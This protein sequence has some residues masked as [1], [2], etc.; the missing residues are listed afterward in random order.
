METIDRRRA[1]GLVAGA[2]AFALGARAAA[3]KA[4]A[5]ATMWRDPGCDCCVGWARRIEAALGVKLM[6]V[7]SPDMAAVKRARGVPAPLRSCHTALIGGFAI[8]GHVPPEDIKRLIA[9]RPRGVAGLAAP[10]MPM[11]SPGMEMGGH[12]EPYQVFAFDRAGRRSVFATH[13]R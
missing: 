11:G 9:S 2:A 4:P 10:G 5:P 3:A 8:E 13:G 7:D 6:I 12:R 1:L